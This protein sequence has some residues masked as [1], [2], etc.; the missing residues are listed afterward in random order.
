MGFLK[1]VKHPGTK[2]VYLYCEKS[3]TNMLLMKLKFVIEVE[4]KPSKTILP[5][6]IA[7]SKK[8]KL[9]SEDKAKIANIKSC[10][11]DMLNIEKLVINMEK[12]LIKLQ[13]RK[14]Y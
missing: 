8:E 9:T 4:M 14:K 13:K 6:I 2:K 7:N 3:I 10:L 12:D 5:N 11:D 1:K